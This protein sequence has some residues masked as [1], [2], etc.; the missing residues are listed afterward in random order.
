VTAKS[1]LRDEEVRRILGLLEPLSADR[2]IVLVGGQAVVFWTRFLG[3]R[4]SDV[5]AF[6][7]L[8]S[9]DIDFEGSA[10]AAR[11]AA[12]LLAAR[13]RLASI[14]DH[15]P[16][17]GIVLFLDADGVERE[18]DFIDEPLGLRARHGGPVDRA[19]RRGRARVPCV[20]HAPRA[21]HGEPD[22]QRADPW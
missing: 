16:N 1:P 19:E 18:I 13:V 17:T 3:E 7:S 9:K 20:G 5:A 2:S 22:L 21:L 10:R 15:T 4:S 8:V 14:D 6:T 12:D 11:R